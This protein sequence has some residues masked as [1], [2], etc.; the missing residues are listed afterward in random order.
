V[1][2]NQPVAMER[3]VDEFGFVFQNELNWMLLFLGFWPIYSV[4]GAFAKFRRCKNAM[5]VEAGSLRF[6]VS[7][8]T[9]RQGMRPTTTG[10][11][12]RA[13]HNGEL[14]AK[15]FCGYRRCPEMASAGGVP[16]AIFALY[17]FGDAL[18]VNLFNQGEH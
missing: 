3:L 7:D 2:V 1:I 4:F 10:G 12:G 5:E 15:E 14:A 18:I 11:L 16:G 6:G 9:P 17:L 8:W 13:T